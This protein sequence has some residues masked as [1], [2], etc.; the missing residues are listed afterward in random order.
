MAFGQFLGPHLQ[1]TKHARPSC[2]GKWAVSGTWFHH[3]M[4]RDAR[5]ERS[6]EREVQARLRRLQRKVGEDLLQI[7]TDAAATKAQVARAAGVDRSF[8]G[9]VEAGDAHASL[10]SLVAIATALGAELSVRLYAG[11]G[12]RLT[13]RH[14]ARMTEAI[15]GQLHPVWVPHLEVVVQRPARGVIDAVFERRDE[16]LLVI[17]EF[18]SALPRLEQQIRWASEKAASIASSP[19][20]G[21]RSPPPV[22]RLLILRSTAATR[23]LAT[24]FEATLRAAYPASSNAAL[25]SLWGGSPWPGSAIIWVR[26]DGD[27]VEVL[28]QP[29]R[30][31]SLGR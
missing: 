4:P 21:D 10:G 6:L 15:L 22:S 3:D 20:V 27:R 18:Q 25:V 2:P 9:R 23:A 11:T 30:G 31:V 17:G 14:Q 8:Y 5:S 26:I 16:P 1:S 28:D 19:I 29:P 12:P 24:S 7:R 13:D